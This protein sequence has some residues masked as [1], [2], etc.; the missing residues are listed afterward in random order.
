VQNI[1]EVNGERVIGFEKD[2]EGYDRLNLLI[3]DKQGSPMLVMENNFW[4]AYSEKLYDLHASAQGKELR[5]VSMDGVTDLTMR[6]DDHPLSEFRQ[7]L[8]KGCEEVSFPESMGEPM[9]EC[10]I[11]SITT[12]IDQFIC[13]IG[14]PETVPT[15]SIKGNLSWGERRLVIREFEIE[16]ERNNVFAM[17]FVVGAKAA[18]SLKASSTAVGVT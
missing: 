3:R 8:V 1:L 11:K 13:D 12:S 6:F 4:T 2:A 17:T 15:W 18:F 16:D 10:L 5:I 14:M 9:K 7:R